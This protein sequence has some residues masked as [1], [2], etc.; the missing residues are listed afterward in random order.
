MK[1]PKDPKVERISIHYIS[2]QLLQMLNL[3]RGMGYTIKW[4]ILHPGKAIK[5]YLFEDR[6]RMVKPFSFLLLVTAIATFLTL[7][8]IFQEGAILQEVHKDPEWEDIPARYK[9]VIDQLLVITQKYFNLIYMS[10]VPF[11]ALA[12]Y[13]IF[14]DARLNLA[15]H[16]V[17]NIYIYC[18]Q[19]LMLIL[20]I[21]FLLHWPPAGFVFTILS[22]GYI[23]YAYCRIF[24]LKWGEGLLKTI[25]IYLVYSFFSSIIFILLALIVFITTG[26]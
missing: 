10:S 17:L 9:T 18:M 16:L 5:E 12:T 8:Y 22:I 26:N 19:T 20:V 13:W 15:E 14:K 11:I 21:P 4:L 6:R 24:D 7:T 3:E 25:L 2:D 23:I 1:V